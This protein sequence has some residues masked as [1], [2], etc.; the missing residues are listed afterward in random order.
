MMTQD[1]TSFRIVLH[2]ICRQLDP[3]GIIDNRK[4][5]CSAGF[6]LHRAV[7]QRERRIG[8][9]NDRRVVSCDDHGRAPIRQETYRFHHRIG[10][11]TIQLCGRLV[12]NDQQGIAYHRSGECHTLLLA[13]G[14]LGGAVVGPVPHPEQ[15]QELRCVRAG[16]TSQ[17]CGNVEMLLDGQMG[18]QVLGRPL[19]DVPD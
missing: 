4:R 15:L 8:L 9:C 1:R 16:G 14:E 2:R 7:P 3:S 5:P 13:P 17:P 11:L 12:G 18:H 6:E 10:G 19:K